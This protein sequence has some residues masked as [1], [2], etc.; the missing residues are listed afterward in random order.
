MF[1]LN[2][3]K[4]SRY[5]G[6]MKRLLLLL[7]LLLLA[8]C[9]NSGSGPGVG[10]QV[11]MQIAVNNLVPSADVQGEDLA[12]VPRPQGFVRAEYSREDWETDITYRAE[13]DKFDEV[14]SLYKQ[15]MP[16]RGWNLTSERS[17]PQG[18]VS[19][20]GY[21]IGFEKGVEMD[22]V[23]ENYEEADIVIRVL[24]LGGT[25]VTEVAITY[26]PPEELSEE[27]SG[28][29]PLNKE[30]YVKEVPKYPE[31]VLFDQSRTQVMQVT[32][33]IDKYY[34][35]NGN[36]E[37]VFNFYDSISVPGMKKVVSQLTTESGS[38]VFATQDN[39]AGVTIN[40]EKDGNY[41]IIEIMKH[42]VSS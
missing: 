5:M 10:T 34:V 35:E 28:F 14:Y 31:A 19:Y 36:V 21:T 12:S 22:Y 20:M 40:L 6:F 42:I 33:Y 32:E 29:K 11:S 16:K 38:I 7:P 18:T 8:G 1:F 23:K 2:V 37:D 17:E 25:K 24:A 39:S 13:G 3:L 41:V 4:K 27:E 26:Y 30:P 15:E 9:V